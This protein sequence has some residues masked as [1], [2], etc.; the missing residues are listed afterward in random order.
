MRLSANSG[1]KDGHSDGQTIGQSDHGGLQFKT[2]INDQGS[3]TQN[4]INA[5]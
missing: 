2:K 5:R 1:K 4:I 3:S